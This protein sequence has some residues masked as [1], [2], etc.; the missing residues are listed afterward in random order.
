MDS[1]G[2]GGTAVEKTPG[3][4]VPVP[5]PHMLPLINRSTKPTDTPASGK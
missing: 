4:R 2:G 3:T 1:T 5:K